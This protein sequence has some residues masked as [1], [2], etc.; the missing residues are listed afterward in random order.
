MT[1]VPLLRKVVNRAR[2]AMPP[3]FWRMLEEGVE[4]ATALKVLEPAP[5]KTAAAPAAEPPQKRR[6]T[7][8]DDDSDDSDNG[9]DSDNSDDG[10]DEDLPFT[11]ADVDRVFSNGQGDYFH[12]FSVNG[13]DE[14]TVSWV[15]RAKEVTAGTLQA[16]YDDHADVQRVPKKEC[17]FTSDHTDDIPNRKDSRYTDV[18]DSVVYVG[19]AGIRTYTRGCIHIVGHYQL[20]EHG[21]GELFP[22]TSAAREVCLDKLYTDLLRLSP[23]LGPAIRKAPS[24]VF[25]PC[26]PEWVACGLCGNRRHCATL[27]TI[28]G[29]RDA[30]AARTLKVGRM[31]EKK[32]K[33]AARIAAFQRDGTGDVAAIRAAAMDANRGT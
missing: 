8:F 5:T 31:C 6:R 14:V 16:F 13:P 21:S 33:A 25:A 10:D 17:F 9:N 30:G 19:R 24:V 4:V 22:L 20:G 1:D 3:V 7:L 18:T 23:A 28:S 15:Y 29:G 11:T 2:G 32:L 26:S 27:C 12:L